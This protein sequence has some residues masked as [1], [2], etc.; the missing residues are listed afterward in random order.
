MRLTGTGETTRAEVLWTNQRNVPNSSSPVLYGGK[1]FMVTDRA[2]MSC[3]DAVSGTE[4]WKHRLARGNYR[5][6]LAAGDGKVYVTSSA[7]VTTVVA[8]EPEFKALAE[9][10]LDEGSNASPAFADGCL[11]LRTQAHLFCIEKEAQEAA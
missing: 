7:G 11:L 8:A 6:S 5:A 4:L 10:Q 1:L 9:N 2:V 3:Y